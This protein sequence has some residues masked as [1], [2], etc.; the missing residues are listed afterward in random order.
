MM[1]FCFAFFFANRKQ[2]SLFHKNEL[3]LLLVLYISLAIVSRQAQTGVVM[4]HT[5]GPLGPWG[6]SSPGSPGSPSS[7]G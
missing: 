7:P 6:P 2:I 5:G 4:R 3:L 1:L